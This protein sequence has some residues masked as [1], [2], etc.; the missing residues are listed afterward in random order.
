MLGSSW[1]T[2][3]TWNEDSSGNPYPLTCLNCHN[4][5]R[6]NG[7]VRN[8]DADPAYLLVE[9]TGLCLVNQNKETTMSISDL[10]VH[11][12]AWADPAT[13]SAKTDDERGLVVVRIDSNG[14][15]SSL[16]KALSS[17]G[18]TITFRNQQFYFPAGGFATPQHM[19]LA[20][21][22]FIRNEVG[23]RVGGSVVNAADVIFTGPASMANDESGTGTDPTPD[24]ICQ[25]CHT[26]T[27]HWRSDGSLA[28]HFS[29]YRCTICHPHDQG[30]RYVDPG[31]LCLPSD[32]ETINVVEQWNVDI[33]GGAGSTLYGQ[34]GVAH[35][36]AP[37]AQGSW[38]VMSLPPLDGNPASV[39]TDPTITLATR[40]NVPSTVSFTLVGS[41]GGWSGLPGQHSLIG[42]Y[43]ILLGNHYFGYPDSVGLK[44]EG[45]EGGE[46][47][48]L[49][50]RTGEDG[51]RNM[52]TVVDLDGDGSLSDETW[53]TTLG[54][55]KTSLFRCVADDNGTII[56]RV[57]TAT[58]NEANFAGFILRK[59]VVVQ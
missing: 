24:G 43:L 44:I 37:D 28:N 49:V 48:E 30:F 54:G 4:P 57:G 13:W 42:D 20:Y 2:L 26:Q 5:H 47:Y 56:G 6:N 34:E 23:H 16:F 11:D 3:D 55:G 38:N 27:D 10:V 41:V 19:A 29:G 22:Q 51:T 58:T 9:F 15:V 32:Q 50:V 46:T 39:I 8:Q 53:V 36:H 25:V 14:K 7:I 45:L 17:D 35:P 21:G 18:S 1:S 12:P 33:Q 31:S 40:D 52:Q 59:I